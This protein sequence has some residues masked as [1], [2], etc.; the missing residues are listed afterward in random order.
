[1]LDKEAETSTNSCKYSLEQWLLCLGRIYD[2]LGAPGS[3][4]VQGD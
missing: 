3:L 1:M 2:S 4:V